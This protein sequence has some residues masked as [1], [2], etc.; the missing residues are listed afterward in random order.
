MLEL[1]PRAA[2]TAWA[3][4]ILTDPDNA[5]RE[6]LVITHSY[7]KPG[8]AYHNATLVAYGDQYGPQY[9]SLADYPKNSSGV[10]LKAWAAAHPNIR[11]I[12]C[13]HWIGGIHHSYRVDPNVAGKPLYGVFTNYQDDSTQPSQVILLLNFAGSAVSLSQIN[14]T[15]GAT[16]GT[17]YNLP[18]EPSSSGIR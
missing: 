15:T 2:A 7:V 1:F 10:N 5:T 12:F 9:Y 18:W 11:A 14:T 8:S 4:G 6:V 3:D 13:G 17:P 16:V